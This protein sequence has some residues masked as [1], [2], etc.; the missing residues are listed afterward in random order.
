MEAKT[1]AT[2]IGVCCVAHPAADTVVGSL[3]ATGG[4]GEL[5]WS[6]TP[7]LLQSWL[8]MCGDLPIGPVAQWIRHGPTE[9]GIAGSSPAGVIS[10]VDQVLQ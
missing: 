1:S 6:A 5:I 9:L 8:P 7:T 2:S 4:V 3:K 10:R